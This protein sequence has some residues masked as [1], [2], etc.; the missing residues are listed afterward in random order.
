MK[1]IV[2]AAAA[3]VALQPI[4]AAELPRAAPA[5]QIDRGA[6][7]GARLRMPLGASREKAHA[8]L[9]LTSFQRIAGEPELR[10][11]KGLELGYA[12]DARLRLSL[13]GQP[14]SSFASGAKGPKGQKIGVSTLGWVGIG[15][16]VVV[17]SLAAV[18]VLC[19]SG[20]I[21]NTDDE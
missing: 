21:C 7:A 5:G 9:A 14:V 11:A 12:G 10:F 13:H 19:G 18:Y 1:I 4:T 20:A 2:A 3:S 16:G 15:V 6:F 8:G 17:T